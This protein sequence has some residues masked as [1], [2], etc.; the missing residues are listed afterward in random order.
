MA[1]ECN[2]IAN[3]AAELKTVFTRCRILKAEDL[4]QLVEL[5]EAV[6]NC[7]GNNLIQDNRFKPIFLGLFGSIPSDIKSFVANSVNQLTITE[8][9]RTV[10]PDEIPIFLFTASNGMTSSE[11]VFVSSTGKG[12]YG[13]GGTITL[14]S[15]NLIQVSEKITENFDLNVDPSSI[16]IDL[17]EIGVVTPIEDVINANGPYNI[18]NISN[19]YFDCTRA[20]TRFLYGW[21]GA[22]G[23]FG[24]GATAAT[25][26]D[27]IIIEQENVVIPNLSTGLEYIAS[28]DGG[29]NRGWKFIGKPSGLI[30][31]HAVDLGLEG[32]SAQGDYSLNIG[33]T[34]SV[35]SFSG[36]TIGYDLLVRDE[37]QFTFAYGNSQ[38]H[39]MPYVTAFGYDLEANSNA[40]AGYHLISGRGNR[41][42]EGFGNNLF[43]TSLTSNS[44]IGLTVLGTANEEIASSTTFA[45]TDPLL[46]VGNGTHT[47]SVLGDWSTAITRSNALV[48]KRNGELILPSTSPAIIDAADA[49]Q[50]VTKEWVNAQVLQ[51]IPTL[52]EVTNIGATTSN[53]ITLNSLN[54]TNSFVNLREQTILGTNIG[55]LELTNSSNTSGLE[56][57]GSGVFR[58]TNGSN[59][60]ELNPLNLSGQHQVEFPDKNGTIAYLDDIPSVLS[61]ITDVPLYPN[62][63][64]SYALVEN[65]GGLSWQLNSG[66][67]DQTLEEV[68][69][70][71]NSATGFSIDLNSDITNVFYQV[72]TFANP[73]EYS[74]LFGNG[75]RVRNLFTQEHY[76]YYKEGEIEFKGLNSNITLNGK[77]LANQGTFTNYLPYDTNRLV[78]RITDGVTTLN[79]DNFGIVDISSLLSPSASLNQEEVEDIVGGMI[80]SSPQ[81]LILVEYDDI[82][83]QLNFT[84]EDDLSLFNNTTSA[85]ISADGSLPMSG[86]LNMDSNNIL[87]VGNITAN[88]INISGGTAD[89]ILL[90]NGTTTS[91]LDLEGSLLALS[92]TIVVNTDVLL[93]H[94]DGMNEV[95]S[96]SDV[97]ITVQP[98]ATINIPVNSLVSYIQKGSG[99][100]IINYGA[101]VSGDS[102][103]SYH[104]GD[105]VTLWHKATNVW[106]AINPPKALDSKV[107]G[108]P[109][110]SDQVLNVVSL[111]QAEYDA[112]TPVTGTFYIITG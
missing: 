49:R 87:N 45:A 73:N 26:D 82:N 63:G 103:Q 112:G 106:V 11:Y 68:L 53:T 23:S 24:S 57:Y 6:N 86:N 93:N 50:V 84:V 90:A 91:K 70:E 40:Q 21:V 2:Q 8:S 80:M 98:A 15:D 10:G 35:Q 48:L 99:N 71:G 101:G 29:G 52:Q 42:F 92:S 59:Y 39:S 22:A 107:T 75:L 60:I 110:G 20:G 81:T 46:I 76:T 38:Y 105:V 83:G 54:T 31:N 108:E 102:V 72:D 95:N 66:T 109:T 25:V 51:E 67:D 64:N 78:T 34:N 74:Q 19:W 14:T 5:I 79:A 94:V 89:D 111:T 69:K 100:I 58:F 55:I 88:T 13:Q 1:I 77:S 65:N 3:V 27:F 33:S 36:V 41:M 43:G 44:G 28:S 56:F 18:Q 9:F 61:D 104:S 47:L 96:A 97:T 17:G 12:V 85:F 32:D 30:G 37:A 4:D 7:S 16:V 62:D